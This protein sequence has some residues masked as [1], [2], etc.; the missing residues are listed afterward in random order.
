MSYL[1]T[2]RLRA[3]ACGGSVVPVADATLKLYRMSEKEERGFT[4]RTADDVRAHEYALMA[5]GRTD[6]NGEFSI[7]ITEKSIYGYRGSTHPYG[8]EPF[9]LDV[10]SRGVE[11]IAR[12]EDIEPVQYTIGVVEPTWNGSDGASVTRWE[13]DIARDEWANVRQALD[14]WSIIGRVTG[15][16]R[17]GGLKVFAYDADVVQDDFLGD[18]VTDSEGRFRIDYPGAAFRKTVVPGADYER[19]G[20]ELYFRVEEASGKVIYEE[21]KARGSRPDRAN[22][23]NCFQVELAI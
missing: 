7:D 18:A 10:V 15:G 3:H 14:T 9:I 6:A 1:F 8:G 13:Y 12:G 2:G 21:G 19:G 11:G 5:Q 4:V 23:G 20:P 22:A 17:L 16:D